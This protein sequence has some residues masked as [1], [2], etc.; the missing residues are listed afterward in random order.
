MCK[1]SIYLVYTALAL[2]LAVGTP[3]GAAVSI[4]VENFSFELP[5]VIKQHCWDGERPEGGAIRD[6]PGWTDGPATS[7][8][9][10]VETGYTTAAEGSW[11]G[12]M[13]S[14][15][16]NVYNLTNFLIGSGDVFE[17]A[18]NARNNWIATNFKISLYYDDN[19][20]R[21]T[22]GTYSAPVTE[23]LLTDPSTLFILT[24]SA[25]T[26]PACYDHQIGIE[27][28]NNTSANST[29]VGFD[30]VQ[31]TLTNPLMR[32]QNPSPAHKSSYDGTS[33]TLTW[34]AGPDLP[35]ADNY[36]VYISDNWADVNSSV[37]AADKGLTSTTSYDVSEL[38]LGKSY[39]W[40]IDT[41]SG[42]NTYRGNI[43]SF[44]TISLTA[45]N[46][47]PDT[48]SNY[49]PVDATLTW[50]A[51]HGA[52][53][54]HVIFFGDNFDDVNN[55]TPRIAG[56]PPF[57]VFSRT[58]ADVNWAPA[59]AGLNLETSKTY[60][61]RVDEVESLA[62]LTIH[63]GTVWSFTTVPVVGLGSITREVWE[64]ITGTAITDLTGNPNY[65]DNP[66][67]T[68]YLPLF[69]TPRDRAD[70]YGTRVHGWLYV[71]TTGNYT[72]WLAADD[73]GELWLN[74]DMITSNTTAIG[75]HQWDNAAQSAPIRLEAGNLYYIMALQK[76]GSERDTLAVA[77]STSDDDT[78]A[79]IIPGKYLLPFEMYSR[80]WSYGPN[81]ANNAIDIR[82]DTNLNWGPGAYA[83]THDVYFGTN[84]TDVNDAGTSTAVI[85]KGRQSETDYIPG[86]L[87]YNTT[88]YWRI[89]EV[90]DAHPDKLWKGNVWNFTTGNFLVVDDFED[91]NDYE[92]NRI[93]DVWADYFVNNTGMTVGH[94]QAPYAET[95]IVHSGRAAMYMRY[96][97]DGTVNEGTAYEKSGTLLYSEA[98][99]QW[100]DAQDW[101]REGVTSLTLWLRGIPASV[102]SFTLGPPIIMTAGGADIWGTSDEFHF[103]Y[104]PLSGAGS[105]TVRVV[106]L[107]NTHNW[108]KAGVM[109]RETLAAD[110]VHTMVCFNPEG[111]I[112]FLQRTATGA[113][114]S[115]AATTALTGIS[116]PVWVRLTRSQNNFTAESSSDGTNW[117]TV[118]SVSLPMLLDAYIGLIAC[119]H[120]ANATCRAEFSDLNT[121]GAVTGDWQSQDIGIESNA[122][123]QL[124]VEL[125][126]DTG[127]TVV[128]KH[129]D[130]AATTVSTWTQWNIPLTDFSSVNLQA[131][132]KMTIGVGDKANPA[133][134]GSGDLYIDDIRLHRP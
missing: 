131:I 46:P 101:T 33:V 129:P 53:K 60:Y 63:K 24:V 120:D 13:M 12:F 20:R 116:T 45:Y 128:V 38:I 85:Y 127:K 114:S 32:A 83:D 58:P 30:N 3:A 117:T 91:Y 61:W 93:F 130:P 7:N 71:E 8:D 67:S 78:T 88:Y 28:D 41:I 72:F 95:S 110:S 77:W 106:S 73:T 66:S 90:N 56:A 64:N 9:S 133:P 57:R 112:E 81:P 2:I 43:W 1:K 22:L 126:D 14:N 68:D 107:T 99:R 103:A 18:V 5:G 37:P 54:G 62:P 97:N 92:P 48:D 79:A 98:E 36:H 108:A 104:K 19:G 16:P 10:G 113:D 51:G 105:L 111:R 82:I 59:E 89:D 96:D 80:V 69:D 25:D 6:V 29:W 125:Q 40:R 123:E 132:K 134:G 39:Y 35:S 17:L 87:D 44:N 31:L 55:I 49:V 86:T 34:V 75:F 27:F 74:N 4:E 100:N 102:G 84:F 124:Y 26:V 70:N 47:V 21:V 109:I 42:E 65:P 115:D 52:A 15:D 122:A 121:T 11:T 23:G 118:G 50:E 119:S 94:L 76:E